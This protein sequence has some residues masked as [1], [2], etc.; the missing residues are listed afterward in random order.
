MEYV[1]DISGWIGLG[2]FLSY[3][4]KFKESL[5]GIHIECHLRYKKLEGRAGQW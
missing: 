4:D 5:I 1:K 2:H 3:K